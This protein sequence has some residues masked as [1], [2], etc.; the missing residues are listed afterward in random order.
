MVF[1]FKCAQHM[2]YCYRLTITTS[3]QIHTKSGIKTITTLTHTQI[4]SS[5]IIWMMLFCR[6]FFF[7]LRFGSAITQYF[8]TNDL[9]GS[10]YGCTYLAYMRYKFFVVVVCFEHYCFEDV[11]VDGF[12]LIFMMHI[13]FGVRL[14]KSPKCVS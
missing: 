1:F 6:I 12:I 4:L 5:H 8:E 10:V 9:C 2:C 14:K 13:A 7:L 11:S 3:H